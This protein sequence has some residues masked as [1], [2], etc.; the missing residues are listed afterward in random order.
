MA[1]WQDADTL[2]IWLIIGLL[3][4]MTLAGFLLVFTRIYMNRKISDAQKLARLQVEHQ[5]ELLNDSIRVQEKER[6]RIARDIHDELISGLNI[7]VLLDNKDQQKA[8]ELLQ[9]SIQTARRI[10]HD[11]SPPLLEEHRFVEFAEELINHFKPEY[12]VDFYV[13]DINQTAIPSNIKLQL[14]RIL[15]EVLNNTLKYAE[16]KSVE[17]VIHLSPT[18]MGMAIRDD[19][20]GFD[21]DDKKKGLG[22]RNIEMRTQMLDG[23]FKLKSEK[24]RGTSYL[25]GFPLNNN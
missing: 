16:A 24:G 2:I 23:K 13:S 14:I 9:Q 25:F 19:G 22:L 20:K 5:K 11:L 6:E 12:N 21:V 7:M 8:S 1:E 17:L 10:S 18:W 3:V 4:L 15:Q